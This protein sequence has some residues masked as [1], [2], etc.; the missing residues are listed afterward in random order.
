MIQILVI[1]ESAEALSRL[2]GCFEQPDHVVLTSRS[3][4]QGFRIAKL[5]APHAIILSVGKS[6]P[7][8]ENF[9]KT[10]RLDANTSCIV[11]L[12]VGAVSHH[13]EGRK[14]MECGADDFLGGG[15]SQDALTRALEARLKR[16]SDLSQSHERAPLAT[17][18]AL[19][20]ML[21]KS[22]RTG[23]TQ[24]E[25]QIMGWICHGKG[26]GDIATILGIATRTV[27]K[28]VEGILGKLGT[29]TRAAAVL[30]A[31]ET[32]GLIRTA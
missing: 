17:P 11:C 27:E 16:R 29:E 23:L 15:C 20:S 10:L 13:E 19:G 28:H 25:S 21:W 9:L 14:A 31:L 12:V 2:A 30:V 1:A 18:E 32:C 26:N 8:C 4:Q 3:F 5:S 7:P 24:R 22:K 6:W